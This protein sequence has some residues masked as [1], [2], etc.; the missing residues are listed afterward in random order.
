MTVRMPQE[1]TQ[2]SHAWRDG[3]M[4]RS[5]LYREMRRGAK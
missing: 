4:A 3:G 5:W 2:L 1:V